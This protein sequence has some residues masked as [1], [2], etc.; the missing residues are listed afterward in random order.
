MTT[1]ARVIGHAGEDTDTGYILA[2]RD[3]PERTMALVAW[4]GAA[5]KSEC[6]IGCLELDE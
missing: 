2:L 5:H 4:D 1:G 6:S 3:E